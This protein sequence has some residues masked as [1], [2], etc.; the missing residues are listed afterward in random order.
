[1]TQ[2]NEHERV[3]EAPEPLSRLQCQDQGERQGDNL[4]QHLAATLAIWL[5]R[6]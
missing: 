3:G 5:S 2:R 1:M 6:P 4:G